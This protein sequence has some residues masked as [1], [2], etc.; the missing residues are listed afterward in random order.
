[1]SIILLI[2]ISDIFFGICLMAMFYFNYPPFG[3]IY[4]LN[5]SILNES[6]T[7]CQKGNIKTFRRNAVERCF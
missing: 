7:L 5:K 2:F 4:E 6:E 3:M 1:M